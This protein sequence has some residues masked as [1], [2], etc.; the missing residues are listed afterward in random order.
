MTK[1]A[2]ININ[3]WP[4]NPDARRRGCLCPSQPKSDTTYK[5]NP[6]CRVHFRGPDTDEWSAM[7]SLAVGDA[8]RWTARERARRSV[9]SAAATGWVDV[10]EGI[11]QLSQ[12]GQQWLA[13]Q[14]TRLDHW[15]ELDRRR[16]A[17]GRWR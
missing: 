4:G 14:R 12:Q 13:D 17:K 2:P 9:K 10:V 1:R 15:E 6:R 5:I 8:R 7:R 16:A 11:P 3:A